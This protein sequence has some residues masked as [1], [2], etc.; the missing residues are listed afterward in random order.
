MPLPL[1]N[2]GFGGVR[3]QRAIGLPVGGVTDRSFF[4]PTVNVGEV[5]SLSRRDHSSAV[6]A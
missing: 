2:T 6:T 3:S 1:Q 5:T 4:M